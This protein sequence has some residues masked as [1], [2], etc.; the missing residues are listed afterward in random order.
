MGAAT[1][2]MRLRCGTSVSYKADEISLW[3]LVPSVPKLQHGWARAQGADVTD[4]AMSH[5]SSVRTGFRV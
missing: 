3:L 5:L 1:M 4:N 2:Q